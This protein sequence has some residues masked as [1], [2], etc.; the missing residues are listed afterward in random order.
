MARSKHAFTLI[1]LLVVISIIALLI[2]ILLPALGAARKTALSMQCLSNERQMGIGFAAFSMAN[3]DFLP[4][5]WYWIDSDGSDWTIEISGY[6]NS[7][8][9]TYETGGKSN[10]VFQCP[11]GLDIGDKHYTGHPILLPSLG[12]GIPDD[13]VRYDSQRRTTEIMIIADGTQIPNPGSIYEDGNARA[14]AYNVFNGDNL[15]LSNRDN[16]L[17]RSSKTDSDD[18]V[19]MGP[20]T[21][22]YGSEGYLRFRHASE[23]ACN[24]LFLDGHAS[25]VQENDFV[26]KNIRLDYYP[27]MNDES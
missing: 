15:T 3:D 18:V 4:W 14:N 9:S 2:G 11:S 23:K 19:D 1:E 6:I 21:D 24:M 10:P 22:D 5:G 25:T 17:Y 8:N 16:W 20:N 13:K 26:L 7:S 27:E 12:W